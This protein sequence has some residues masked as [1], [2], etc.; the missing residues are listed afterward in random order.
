MTLSA[1]QRTHQRLALPN[2]RWLGYAEYGDPAGTPLL[3]CHGGLSCR[4]DVAF[5]AQTCD[6]LHVRLIAPDRPGIGISSPVRTRTMTDWAQDVR[7]LAEA[8]GLERFALLGWSM[9]APY[10]LVCAALIPEKLT[11]VATI[12]CPAPLDRPGAVNALGLLGDRI[13]FALSKRAPTLASWMLSASAMLPDEVIKWDLLREVSQ[14]DRDVLGPLPPRE[15]CGFYKE[16]F[17]FTAL[18]TVQDYQIEGQPWGFQLEDVRIPVHLWQGEE[19]RLA[20][21][22]G[23]RYL[24]EHLPAAELTLVPNAGH[25][26]LHSSTERVIGDLTG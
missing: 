9:G 4:I 3:Y 12:G 10:A 1:E 23:A 17:R 2:G 11:R 18:G 24:A 13:F 25:F 15:A 20:P 26:L 16:A 5:A 7:L 14:P 22:D 6:A 8:L 19:D 21:L